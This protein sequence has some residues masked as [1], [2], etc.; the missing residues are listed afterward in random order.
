[1]LASKRIHLDC[2]IYLSM[3]NFEWHEWLDAKE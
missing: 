1:M 3:I 2:L